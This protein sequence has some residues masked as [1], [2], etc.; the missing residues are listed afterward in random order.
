[1]VEHS[2]LLGVGEDQIVVR[3]IRGALEVAAQLVGHLIGERN[4]ARAAAGLGCDPVAAHVVA[5]YADLACLPIDVAPAESEQL[6]LAQPRHRS[7]QEK[8]VVSGPERLGVQV[9]RA[10]KGGQLLL[11]QEA[12][13]RAWLHDWRVNQLPRDFTLTPLSLYHVHK[14]V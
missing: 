11:V 6:A 12:D 3:S 13:I 7:G 10:E 14:P 1:M 5:A 2:A 4:G 8:G 9:D